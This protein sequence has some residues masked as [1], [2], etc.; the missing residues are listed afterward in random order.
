M[1]SLRST[2]IGLAVL[3]LGVAVVFWLLRFIIGT[4]LFMIRI[5]VAVIV[6][7]LL[8]YIG[9]RIWRAWQRPQQY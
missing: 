4:I 6:V 8:G 2:L 3:L 7:A 5:G 9:Y 1:A